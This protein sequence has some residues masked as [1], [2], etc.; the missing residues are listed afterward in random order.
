MDTYL[1]CLETDSLSMSSSGIQKAVVGEE[2]LWT[3]GDEQLNV[4]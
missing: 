2:D 4:K 3:H 1:E